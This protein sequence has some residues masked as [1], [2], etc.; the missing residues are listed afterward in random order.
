VQV[1]EQ[2]RNGILEPFKERRQHMNI[3]EENFNSRVAS[4][5]YPG[6][7]IVMGLSE[8]GQLLQLYWIMGR[9]DNSRNRIFENDDKGMLRTL[10]A[11]PSKVQD[12]SLVIYEAMLERD[13]H[14]IVSNGDQ[15]RT[16]HQMLKM[17]SGGFETA[18][19]ARER[20]PD[21]P[22]Y[23]PRISGMITLDRGE[24]FFRYS[25]LKA[26]PLNPSRSD[27]NFY[28]KD[29]V[30]PGLGFLITTYMGDGNPLPS[31][32]GEP[33]PVPMKGTPDEILETY[34]NS[35]NEDNK[36]SLAL[37]SID[38]S[39]GSSEIRTLNR[40]SKTT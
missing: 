33:L 34:W 32:Q 12:P 39:N 29:A 21:A 36:I 10:P 20:E 31:F 24:A 22:N 40:Y 27:R 6:R 1:E 18:S 17:E 28:Y 15:T 4:N 3:A 7:G 14:F 16:I 8:S 9:S 26:N 19:V 30:E 5:P 25:I 13:N 23:T 35:L 2:R 11:D 37:K 38:P